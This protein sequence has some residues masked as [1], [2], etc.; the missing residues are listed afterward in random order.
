MS[1]VALPPVA[2]VPPA[3]VSAA[4]AS[5][6]PWTRFLLDVALGATDGAKR[7]AANAI[8]LGLTLPQ[9]AEALVQCVMAA[10]IT[11]WNRS[12]CAVM[13]HAVEAAAALDARRRAG[14]AP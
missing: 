2:L 9:L 1:E 4:Q 3:P 8:G 13:E 6:L 5:A 7:H 14:V 10:G 12:G 11:T